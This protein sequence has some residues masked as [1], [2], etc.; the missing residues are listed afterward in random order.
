MAFDFSL[1]GGMDFILIVLAILAIVGLFRV[2]SV[3]GKTVA[4]VAKGWA[5]VFLI[6]A[7][8]VSLGTSNLLPSLGLD[9]GEVGLEAGA[10]PVITPPRNGVTTPTTPSTT[11][12]TAQQF[13]INTFRLQ[14]VE[15][16][17]NS[18][19][20]GNGTLRIYDKDTDPKDPNAVALSSMTASSGTVSTSTPPITLD[21]PYRVVY[22][23]LGSAYDI[24]F[25]IIEFPVEGFLKN[26]GEYLYTLKFTSIA[27]IDDFINENS[28]AANGQSDRDTD[29]TAELVFT[30][31]D[32]LTYDESVGDQEFYIQPTISFSG[33]NKEVHNAVLCY[34]WDTTNPP[35]GNEI[36]SIKYQRISGDDLGFASSQ[37]NLWSSELCNDVGNQESG[38]SAE[39]RLTFTVSEINLDANDD[40][41][42]RMDDLGAWRGKD[43]LVANLGATHD[44][45]NI[46]A[47][48]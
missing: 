24:D 3:K 28:T 16:H 5:Y 31:T 39:F 35:E 47:R 27:L 9:L 17:T 30:A 41:T 18:V 33:G 46:D 34:V 22:D 21:T 42:L 19:T 7:V 2:G 4:G 43:V 14:T 37:T 20:Q 36:T 8:L 6:A 15:K 44:T 40:W 25:G 1:L 48:A 38:F 10:E 12:S 45:L 29:G 26:T 13:P 23:G 11:P 32:T